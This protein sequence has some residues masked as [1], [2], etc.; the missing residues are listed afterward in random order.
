MLLVVVTGRC[1]YLSI[2]TLTH[3]LEV[4]F[5]FYCPCRNCSTVEL[6]TNVDS[7]LPSPLMWGGWTSRP[8]ESPSS[9]NHS[10]QFCTL[11]MGIF[12]KYIN[13][14]FFFFFV[15]G[16]FS[17]EKTRHIET[18][19]YF[20]CSGFSVENGT[21]NTKWLC[22][23]SQVLITSGDLCLC[24]LDFFGKEEVPEKDKSHVCKAEFE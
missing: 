18:L 11:N 15:R 21:G 5:S 20:L 1:D 13:K 12:N 7:S 23:F 22:I 9:L 3:C 2:L 14:L 10:V 17:L 6:F 8:P 16:L 4:R 24:S 19:S